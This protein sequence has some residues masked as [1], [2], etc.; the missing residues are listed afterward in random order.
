MSLDDDG[1]I[2]GGVPRSG[3]SLMRDILGSHPDVAMFPGELPV[4]RLAAGD[5]PA[6]DRHGRD[7]REYLVGELVNHPRMAQAGIVLD[8]RAI[9]DALGS[10]PPFTPVAVLAHVL[11]QLA[12]QAGRPRW[13]V[14]D[15]L[16]EFHTDRLLAELPRATIVHMVRDPRDVVTSSRARWGA[17][18]QHVVSA[19]DAWRRSAALGRRQREDRTHGFVSVRYEDLVA[20]P[21]AILRKVCNVAGLAY[22][23]EMLERS[24]RPSGWGGSSDA[25]SRSPRVIFPDAVSRHVGQLPAGDR[26]FIELRAGREMERWGYPR[27]PATLTARDRRL[28][29]LRLVQEAAWR[30]LRRWVRRPKGW[31]GR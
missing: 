4:A 14:K 5:F 28:V 21:P 7:P 1:I 25:G 17:A 24:T 18:A 3:T 22:R 31:L 20:D 9:L 30:A 13:G 27:R 2:V 29:A 23:P 15:P 8:A 26:R 19:T 11:R 12:R 10:E 16:A 6:P